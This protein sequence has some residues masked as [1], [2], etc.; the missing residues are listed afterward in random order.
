MWCS[1]VGI[2]L[3]L[4]CNILTAPC[5]AE[6]QQPTK[7]YRVGWLHPGSRSSTLE[8][9]R[10]GLRELGYIEGQ[11]LVIEYRYAEGRDDQLADLA[12]ELVRLQV[13]VIVAVGVAGIRVAQHAT[14]TIPIVMAGITDPVAQGF[15]ASL[16]R[17]GGNITGLST[18]NE[19][20][21]GKRLE[22]L[23]EMVPQSARIAVLTNPG[24]PLHEPWMNT[25]TV[26]ARALGLQ[27][28]VAELR[29]PD[30]LV[31]AFAAMTR[32]GADALIVLTDP[33]LL[34]NLHGRIVDLAATHRLPAMYSQRFF[35]DAGGLM[36]YGLSIADMSQRLAV[37][38]DKTLKGATP[39][40]LPVEQPTKFEL[41]INLKTAKALGLTIPPTLLFQADGVIQ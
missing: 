32:A 3:I 13:D 25:L 40:D 8:P 35:V 38:V 7:V 1:T 23:K 21:F 10:Q 39:G 12:T 29:S 15:V 14:R 5:A 26:A 19:D 22:L 2:I 11:N 27:L 9:F 28:H 36:F 41:I 6:A 33:A 37:Y 18:L 4:A 31:N 17:P 24:H 30:E 16:A 34:A 20:L